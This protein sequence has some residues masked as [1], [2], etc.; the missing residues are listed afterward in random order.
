MYGLVNRAIQQMVCTEH[1]ESVWDEVKRRADLGD[2][3]FF[4]TYEAY[5]DDV[6]HRLVAAVSEVLNL[7]AKAVMQ[8][9]GTFWITYTANEGYEQLL[10]STGE[11]FPEFLDHLD[12]LHARAGLAFPQLQPPSFRC[13]HEPNGSIELEYRS[14]REGLAPMVTGLLEGLGQRFDTP[15]EVE[16]TASREQ[17]APVD[18]FHIRHGHATDGVIGKDGGEPPACQPRHNPVTKSDAPDGGSA[19]M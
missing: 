9:F 3:D 7:P 1:G 2:L 10:E 8:A 5:P 15:I 6:T 13:T 17:G 16:Q 19:P 11:T 4:A 18:L 12:H 14:S